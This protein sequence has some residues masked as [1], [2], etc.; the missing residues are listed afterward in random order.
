MMHYLKVIADSRPNLMEA[1]FRDL[2]EPLTEYGDICDMKSD[3]Y[4][5]TDRA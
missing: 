1:E 2:E 3:D 4:G 5:R